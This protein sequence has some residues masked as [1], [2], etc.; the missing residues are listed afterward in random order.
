MKK[1]LIV[2]SVASMIKQFIM[3]DINLLNNLGFEVTVATNFD[4][5]GNIKPEES[6]ELVSELKRLGMQV[7]QIDFNRYPFN[8]QNLNSFRR[9]RALI[10]KNKYELIHCHSPIG[11]A[12]TR[13][14]TKNIKYINK[15]VIYTVHGFHFFDK[16]PLKNWAFYPLERYLMKYTDLLITINK[17][18]YDRAST[19]D[20]SKVH[21]IPGVGIDLERIK[22]KPNDI[23]FRKKYEIPEEATI[24]VSV[25]EL[26]KNKNHIEVI[27]TL[28][29]INDKDI[30]YIII[31]DGNLYTYLKNCI[32]KS[33]MRENIILLGYRNDIINILKSSDI[34]IFPSIREG[35]SV[36]LMEAMACG[37]PTI[38]SNI[39]GN[40]DLI[41]NNKGGYLYNHQNYKELE[42]AILELKSNKETQKQFGEFNK[43]FI[44]NFSLERINSLMKN[45]YEKIGR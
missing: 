29:K 4:D 14:A 20:N 13:I 40:E 38:V 28:N 22:Q 1:A 19:W 11:A 44:Q 15:F 45:I 26:N 36:A 23:E 12:V 17:Q 43:N 8:K 16:A 34:F 10:K 30:F 39:R 7:E 18:D 42:R 33:K 6:K 3:P 27:N 2:A 5:P 35:L 25:G 24:I 41:V 21:Y 9:I 37:L 32:E 31:G